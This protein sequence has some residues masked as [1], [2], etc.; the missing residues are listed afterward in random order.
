M[1]IETATKRTIDKP[2]IDPA[3]LT[4]GEVIPHNGT[5]FLR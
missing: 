1:K 5:E 2:K 4:E 3:K